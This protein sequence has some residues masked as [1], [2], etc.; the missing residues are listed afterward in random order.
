MT[1]IDPGERPHGPASTRRGT[2][3]ITVPSTNDCT[4]RQLQYVVA[5]ADTLGFHKAAARCHVSQPALSAQVQQLESVLGVKLFERNRRRVLVTAA[6][7]DLTARARRIL[8]E[9]NDLVASAR[10]AREP[11]TGMLRVGIIPTI[12][13]Y[14]LPAVA[15]V[16]GVR[17]PKLSLIYREEK[18]ADIV[19]E[20][21]AGSIDAGI[22]ALEADIGDCA[23]AEIGW[24]AFVAALPKGHPLARKRQVSLSD[25]E[26]VRML[27]LDEGH[28]FRAQAL[29]LCEKARAQECG[30]RATSLGT[31]AQMVAS[32]AGATLLP[33][34]AVPVENRSGQLEIRPFA[35]PVPG[36]TLAL[37]WRP[38]APFGDALRDLAKAFHWR[39]PAMHR[40]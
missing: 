28:C 22:L 20:L 14:L 27:L 25:L 31:L 8:H 39:A 2:P 34:L 3:N 26:D 13:P 18:T 30:F 21:A 6:G 5:I 23:R 19:H 37:V 32:G 15:P 33:S 17:Y 11:F 29:A 1:A 24:D 4:L 38:H 12:A 10:R 35:K 16:V 7:E 36:R 9:V 40:R